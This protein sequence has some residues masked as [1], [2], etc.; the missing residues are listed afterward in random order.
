MSPAQVAE[1]EG[2]RESGQDENH[3]PRTTAFRRVVIFEKVGEISSA[4]LW[5][6]L[7]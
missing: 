6:G 2:Q 3:F 1:S 5:R 4:S 7:V